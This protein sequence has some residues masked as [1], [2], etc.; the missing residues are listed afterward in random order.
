ME[1]DK[2]SN[3]N[4][5]TR[6]P[7]LNF[8]RDMRLKN[9]NKKVTEVAKDAGAVWNTMNA[10]DKERYYIMARS[11]ARTKRRRRRTHRD[12]SRRSRHRRRRSSSTS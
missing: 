2:F 4:K 7:F 10:Q 6:N 8:L 1:S 9:P 3:S 11:A 12:R 5:V